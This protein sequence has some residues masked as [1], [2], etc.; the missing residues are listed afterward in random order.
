[1]FLGVSVVYNSRT[2]QR[3]PRSQP[4]MERRIFNGRGTHNQPRGGRG[5]NYRQVPM[6]RGNHVAGG[7]NGRNGR[8]GHNRNNGRRVDQVSSAQQLNDQLDN[9]FNKV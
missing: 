8:N 3:G 5:V 6:R 9:Y 2:Q 4:V 1:M 7:R